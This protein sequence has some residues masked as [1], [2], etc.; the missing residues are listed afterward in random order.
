MIAGA[1]LKLDPAKYPWAL[2]EA[3]MNLDKAAS[4][5]ADQ[6]P[7]RALRSELAHRRSALNSGTSRPPVAEPTRLA[8]GG[9]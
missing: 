8:G 9:A 4:L 6:S 7:V 1:L 5:A 3:E 2:A